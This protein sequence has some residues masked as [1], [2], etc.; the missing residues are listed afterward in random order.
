MAAA[1][2]LAAAAARGSFVEAGVQDQVVVAALAVAAVVLAAAPREYVRRVVVALRAV[3]VV[4]RPH[5][6][7]PIDDE[8]LLQVRLRAHER[9]AGQVEL[10]RRIEA[11]VD[12][13]LREVPAKKRRG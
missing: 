11:V 3:I 13:V 5:A 8:V 4:D 1:N 7:V 12:A 9:R 2:Y 6:V 10:L